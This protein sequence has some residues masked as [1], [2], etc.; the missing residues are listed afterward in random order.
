M[1]TDVIGLPE[2]SNIDRTPPMIVVSGPVV[3]EDGKQAEI[4]FTANERVSFREGSQVG[5]SFNRTVK[6]N[7]VYTFNFADMVGNTVAVPVQVEGIVTET[8]TMLMLK[9]G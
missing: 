6:E 5:E 9:R 2:V 4:T 8:L 3:R 7:G 1:M